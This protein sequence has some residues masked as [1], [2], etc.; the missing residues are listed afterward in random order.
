M[1]QKGFIIFEVVAGILIAHLL[2][3]VFNKCGESK[4][5]KGVACESV[6]KGKA[7]AQVK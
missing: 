3:T 5:N 1:N 4:D 6:R 7:P 2:V